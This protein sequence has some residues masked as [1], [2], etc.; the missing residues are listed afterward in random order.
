MCS[1]VT[2]TQR[3]RQPLGSLI[4][5][6]NL[7]QPV[8]HVDSLRSR[9]ATHDSASCHPAADLVEVRQLQ[10]PASPPVLNRDSLK[11]QSRPTYPRVPAPPPR[12]T[13]IS[14][15]GTYSTLTCSDDS[16]TEDASN[17][18]STH[19]DYST[20]VPSA[21]YTSSEYASRHYIS[22]FCFGVLILPSYSGLMLEYCTCG[23]ERLD[24]GRVDYECL[25]GAG[26][27]PTFVVPV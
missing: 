21:A 15:P 14:S 6:L 10:R 3:K 1:T 7:P 24:E 16:S 5:C 18:S 19:D 9:P 27:L 22:A 17:P 12:C 13:T 11:L 4:D 23:C 26:A 2:Q 25:Y 8:L 20:L